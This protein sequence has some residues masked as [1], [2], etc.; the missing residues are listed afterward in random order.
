MKS[1]VLLDAIHNPAQALATAQIKNRLGQAIGTVSSVDVGPDGVARAV[2]ADVGGF[3]GIGEHRVAIKAS[4]LSYLKS[5]DLL[6]TTM[7]K[8]QIEALTPELPPH[9]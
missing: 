6:V 3:L 1:A 7:T 9:S 8:K 2:H 4:S 5:R